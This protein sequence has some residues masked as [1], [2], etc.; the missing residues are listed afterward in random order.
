MKFIEKK[1]AREEE[2][3]NCAIISSFP[4]LFTTYRSLLSSKKHVVV[5]M[6]VK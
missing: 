2:K 4:S 3:I 6:L 1:C 5:K